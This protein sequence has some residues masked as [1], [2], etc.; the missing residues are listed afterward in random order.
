MMKKVF[1]IVV[2][3]L[4]GTALVVPYYAGVKAE[5]ELREAVARFS[6][7]PGYNVA[8][9]TYDR[10]WLS[11]EATLTVGLDLPG[12]AGADAAEPEL[13]LTININHGPFL[14]DNRTFGWY[15]WELDLSDDQNAW[16]REHVVAEGEEQLYRASGYMSLLGAVHHEDELQPFKVA[17]AQRDAALVISGYQG[18]L[19]IDRSR[20]LSYSGVVKGIDLTAEDALLVIG[21]I[22]LALNG[23]LSRM[24]WDTFLYPSDFLVNVA[25]I[26]TQGGG[27][28][29]SIN[30][31]GVEGAVEMPKGE[32]WFT[33]MTST[34]IGEIVTPGAEVR[35]AT[36]TMAYE[37]ISLAAYEAY[38]DMVT[39]VS[40]SAGQGAFDHQQ[41]FT[42]EVVQEF[43]AAG[44]AFAL[45]NLSF[46]MPE[47]EFKGQLQL[48]L[49]EGFALPGQVMNPLALVQSLRLEASAELDRSLA[50]FLA[51]A[52]SRA[53]IEAE[54]A[55]AADDAGASSA[56]IEAALEQ[57]AEVVLGML[58]AQGIMVEEGDRLKAAV[59]FLNG[60]FMLNG[61]PMPLPL[62]LL[63]G[64]QASMQPSS[65]QP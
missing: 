11:T 44:P 12:A 28:L 18:K 35:D 51:K 47:G 22:S 15:S 60:E 34:T 30:N 8:W 54:I 21:R 29:V 13:P 50:K 41:F 24:D 17:E 3:L 55:G 6:S 57:Q 5:S 37:R 27:G 40:Q 64:G 31:L 14:P 2:L 58:M 20:Q 65:V 62:D 7:Y 52:S 49:P 25:K 4:I 10:G 43:L 16:L 33:L 42:P 23:D 59:Q 39:H 32:N 48:S 45:R 9:T 53:D 63:M 46:S 36:V 38:M 1:G 61:K 56:E 19:Q 26:Q